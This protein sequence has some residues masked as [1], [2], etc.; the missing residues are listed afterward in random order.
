MIRQNQNL[1]MRTKVSNNKKL[2]RFLMKFFSRINFK[3][4]GRMDFEI[5]SHPNLNE[6]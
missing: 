3:C 1:K 6:T 2:T 4:V 5:N